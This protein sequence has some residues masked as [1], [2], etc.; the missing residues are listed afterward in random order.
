MPFFEQALYRLLTAWAIVKRPIIHV[1]ADEPVREAAIHVTRITQGIGE[2]LLAMLQAVADT[3]FQKP[4]DLADN[5]VSQVAANHVA[6]QRQRQARFLL[7]PD[8]Q[9][10]EEAQ[11][12]VLKC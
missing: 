1:H 8:A 10:D 2:L 4:A 12:L 9:I 5:F 11:S 3:L 7:P 6:A